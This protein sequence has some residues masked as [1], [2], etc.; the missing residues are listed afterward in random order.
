MKELI[1]QLIKDEKNKKEECYGLFRRKTGGW[2]EG[3]ARERGGIK[4]DEKRDRRKKKK[5]R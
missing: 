4:I 3:S 5:K 2:R 1:K